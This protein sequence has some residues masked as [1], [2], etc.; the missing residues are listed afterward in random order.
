MERFFSYEGNIGSFSTRKGAND[1]QLYIDEI[2]LR[3]MND[4]KKA[5]ILLHCDLALV[6]YIQEIE[7]HDDEERYMRKLFIY[8]DILYLREIRV[9]NDE[10]KVCK[11]VKGHE[12]KWL[13][14]MRTP[15]ICGPQGRINDRKQPPLV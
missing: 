2:E 6:D 10:G 13:A 4:E 3:D 8:D 12:D 5:P 1:G 14:R 15:F 9:F 7:W 11:I